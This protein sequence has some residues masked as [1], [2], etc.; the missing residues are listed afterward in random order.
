MRFGRTP[1]VLIVV[2]LAALATVALPTDLGASCH[3][4]KTT[5]KA[6]TGGCND[7][8]QTLGHGHPK[9]TKRK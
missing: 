9:P 3:A 5:K 6:G 2:A 7:N 8:P 1:R 4:R